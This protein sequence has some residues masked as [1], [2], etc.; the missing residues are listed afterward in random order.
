MDR[1]LAA[2][3]EG[4]WLIARAVSFQ[5]FRPICTLRNHQRHRV[6]DRWTTCDRNTALC[7]KVH[8]AVMKRFRGQISRIFNRQNCAGQN[9]TPAALTP[10]HVRTCVTVTYSEHVPLRDAVN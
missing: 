5:D 1:L 3:S 2:K 9:R 8:C 4:V 7:T 6:T 10:M